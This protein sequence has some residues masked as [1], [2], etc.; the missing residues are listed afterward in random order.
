MKALG[1]VFAITPYAKKY[2][3]FGLKIQINRDEFIKL[4]VALDF[5]FEIPLAFGYLTLE[6]LQEAKLNDGI[7]VLN[8]CWT[9][10]DGST[11]NDDELWDDFIF[12]E[13]WLNNAKWHGICHDLGLSLIVTHYKPICD[14]IQEEI[15]DS[16]ETKDYVDDPRT[17]IYC[18]TYGLNGENWTDEHY[19]TVTDS[20]GVEW[21]E[22]KDLM[23]E[24]S[25]YLG[26]GD[27][28]TSFDAVHKYAKSYE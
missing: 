27:R 15:I 16:S 17:F 13:S 21:C 26:Y 1:K 18:N 19:E 3:E 22:E 4:K 23:H 8:A 2:G 24:C 25:T 5:E 14:L 9:K 11:R 12:L 28:L 10:Q 7:C 20:L 6:H